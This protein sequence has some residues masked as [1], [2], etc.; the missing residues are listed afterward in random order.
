MKWNA[1][2]ERPDARTRRIILALLLAATSLVPL[3]ADGFPV[4]DCRYAGGPVLELRLTRAQLA[5]HARAKD[6]GSPI[7]LTRAQRRALLATGKVKEAPTKLWIYRLSDLEGDCSCGAQNLG[8]V[9]KPG[10]IE[11]PLDITG[12]DRDMERFGEE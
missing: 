7:L 5:L 3:Q 11:V 6:P 1:W 4:K 12:S 9:F 8:F 10:W 2:T